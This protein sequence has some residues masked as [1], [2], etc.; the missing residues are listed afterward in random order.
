MRSALLLA[1][2]ATLLVGGCLRS[3]SDRI[4]RDEAVG[5]AE[6][7]GLLVQVDDGLAVVRRVEPGQLELWSQAP[8]LTVRVT[9]SAASSVRLVVGN[10]MPG[11]ALEVREGGATATL[12]ERPLPTRGVWQL[13]LP[14][15]ATT[16]RVAPP[17]A[18]TRAPFRFAVLSDVQEA[19]PRVTDIYA[20][21][22]ADPSLRFVYSAGDLTENGSRAQLEE[23]EERMRTLNI[24]VYATLGNHELFT[25]ELP[26]HELFG[27]G[28]FHFDFK[29][30]HY[31]AVDSGDGTLD[32]QAVAW[33]DGWL[34]HAADGVHVFA[35]HI[36]PFDPSG[37]RSGAFGSRNEAAALVSRL[38]AGKV[39]LA[40][41]GH[42]H[43]LYSFSH[44]GVPA[45]ISGGGGAI[46]EKFDGIERHYLVVSVDPDAGVEEVS[47]VRVD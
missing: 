34:A 37:T 39:D 29:G 8:V 36:P 16:L 2:A 38:A 46:P 20:R 47:V 10:A 5:R 7:H 30:V 27:R 1:V 24:P 43:S 22:N 14:A 35:T 3:P 13:E 11:A 42:V 6:A 28:T 19:L 21:M 4:A 15:G 44:G 25:Q 9:A 41:Y 33:L 17:D 26:W 31:S 23:F 40:L 12:L 18:D 45:F 32:P